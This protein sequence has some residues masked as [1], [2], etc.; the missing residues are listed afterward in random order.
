MQYS[1]HK[2]KKKMDVN[3]FLNK[4]RSS[5]SN[6]ENSQLNKKKKRNEKRKQNN[7]MK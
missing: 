7:E 6:R 2:N 1:L 5:S 3:D 4:L